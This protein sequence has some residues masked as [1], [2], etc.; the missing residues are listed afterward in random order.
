VNVKKLKQAIINRPITGECE[1]DLPEMIKLFDHTCFITKYHDEYRLVR[2]I[3]KR[4]IALKIT[5]KASDAK[6]I[7]RSKKLSEV[8]SGTFSH[9]AYYGVDGHY[10]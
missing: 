2:K 8:Q 3:Y 10:L 6:E 5:I 4:K 7:I 1:L 9:A